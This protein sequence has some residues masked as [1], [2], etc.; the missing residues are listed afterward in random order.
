MPKTQ[1]SQDKQLVNSEQNGNVLKLTLNRDQ[2]YINGNSHVISSTV[3]GTKFVPTVEEDLEENVKLSNMTSLPSGHLTLESEITHNESEDI[4]VHDSEEDNARQAADD[5]NGGEEFTEY[6]SEPINEVYVGKYNPHEILTAGNINTI[7]LST[8]LL[9]VDLSVKL[10][11]NNV[12]LPTEKQVV[13][14]AEVR[15]VNVVK[16]PTEKHRVDLTVAKQNNAAPVQ[17]SIPGVP[18][19]S[20]PEKNISLDKNLLSNRIIIHNKLVEKQSPTPPKFGNSSSIINSKVPNK[21]IPQNVPEDN[22][23]STNPEI[24]HLESSFPSPVQQS[25]K[26]ISSQTDKIWQ[27]PLALNNKVNRQKVVTEAETETLNNKNSISLSNTHLKEPTT[28]ENVPE[29]VV[30]VNNGARGNV[31]K[32][33]LAQIAPAHPKLLPQLEQNTLNNGL[34]SNGGNKSD[35]TVQHPKVV[36][37]SPEAGTVAENEKNKPKDSVHPKLRGQISSSRVE[38][39][40]DKEFQPKKT[41]H[42]KL[43]GQIS[44]PTVEVTADKV[45]EPE[46]S[47]HPKLT[48]QISSGVKVTADK[49]NKPEESVHPKF[50]GEISSGIEVT[51]DK[52]NKPNELI[53]PKVR[54][55]ISSSEVEIVPTKENY[56]IDGDGVKSVA[57]KLY[58]FSQKNN[59]NGL[60]NKAIH[61]VNLKQ[62]QK[63]EKIVASNNSEER[64]VLNVYN[65]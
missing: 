49:E 40:A 53:Q 5:S 34:D 64:L 25:V 13:G 56:S 58:L 24:L 28:H 38:V 23:Q 9:G 18:G 43:R 47:A 4:Q 26:P 50:T 52:E 7:N 16:L 22:F 1:Q 27:P 61:D 45:K 59:E 39:T 8:E 44:S 20:I 55:Q 33:S 11:V 46:K 31:E 6:V 36:L 29:K 63:N 2:K 19:V 54:D 42:P 60:I 41:V 57:D 21:L 37:T 65:A 48:G 62:N 3:K 14:M 51:A 17:I 15:P 32:I 12:N 30:K 35:N 10:P